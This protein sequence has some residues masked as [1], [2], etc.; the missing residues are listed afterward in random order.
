MAR[1]M[2]LT[3]A[4]LVHRFQRSAAAAADNGRTIAA[5]QRIR[6]GY[7]AAWTIKFCLLFQFV[8]GHYCY[9]SSRSCCSCHFP[10]LRLFYL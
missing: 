10:V 9:T 7:V 4:Q 3:D 5:D 6:H 2:V 1:R 8:A